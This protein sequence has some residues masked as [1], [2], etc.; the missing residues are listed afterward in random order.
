VLEYAAVRAV[1]SRGR[2]VTSRRLPYAGA[3]LG[4]LVRRFD[5]RHEGVARDALK[6]CLPDLLRVE[7]EQILTNLYRTLG[8]VTVEMMQMQTAP[9]R[10]M[11]DRTDTSAL[12]ELFETVRGGQS[13]VL[14][15]GH[16][17]N[18]ELTGWTMAAHA[19][20]VSFAR[21]LDN[22]LL[23]RL[24]M[25]TR[26]RT[27]HN[28][29]SKFGGL[30][31]MMRHLKKGV[32]A[33]FLSDQDAGR[34]GVWVPLFGRPASTAD[35]GVQL[36]MKYRLPLYVVLMRREADNV[37]HRFHVCRRVRFSDTGDREADVRI[38]LARCNAILEDTIRRDPEQWFGWLHR[39]W[40]TR[41]PEDALILDAEG[42]RLDGEGRVVAK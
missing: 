22:P 26:A 3:V 28:V 33:G 2:I 38:T 6:R 21:P 42:R 39:R 18:W 20:M 16:V 7:R 1:S 30:R 11:L 24:I 13:C 12:Q 15:G 36:A 31:D 32:M 5:R 19:P 17:D 40:K 35:T 27:G 25:R 29:V 9:P 10:R 41:P 34:K 37:C 14:F 23:D 8:M 4:N